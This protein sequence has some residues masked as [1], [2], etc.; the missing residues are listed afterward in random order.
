MSVRRTAS[1]AEL[2][3]AEA[4]RGKEAAPGRYTVSVRRPTSN[5][6]ALTRRDCRDP[7]TRVSQLDER[8]I[9]TV[10][11]SQGP[12]AVGGQIANGREKRA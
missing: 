10:S 6:L 8:G 11:G 3:A 1:L 7:G 5:T 12:R 2:V 4:V 9:T